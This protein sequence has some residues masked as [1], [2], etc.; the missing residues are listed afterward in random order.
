M[1][2]SPTLS[3]SQ[4]RARCAFIAATGSAVPAKA[5]PALTARIRYGGECSGQY[6]VPDML[7]LAQPAPGHSIYDSYAPHASVQ[8]QRRMQCRMPLFRFPGNI[9]RLTIRQRLAHTISMTEVPFLLSAPLL[10]VWKWPPQRRSLRRR[11][12]YACG[13]VESTSCQR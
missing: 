11:A 6:S 13:D 3:L 10:V 5:T 12:L 7:L 8:R 2:V 9:I 1:L 4:V